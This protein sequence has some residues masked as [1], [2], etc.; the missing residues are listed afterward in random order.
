MEEEAIDIPLA[1]TTQTLHEES[2]ALYKCAL[3]LT[4]AKYSHFFCL[5]HLHISSDGASSPRLK[6]LLERYIAT[7]KGEKAARKL[8]MPSDEPPLAEPT[9]KKARPASPPL[10]TPDVVH[11]HA[12]QASSSTSVSSS[13]MATQE[14]VSA[15]HRA[16]GLSLRPRR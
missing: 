14:A 1:A 3:D 16:F 7:K 9:Q 13:D 12:D 8:T 11:A 5:F 10:P 2:D 4:G 15:I 6:A